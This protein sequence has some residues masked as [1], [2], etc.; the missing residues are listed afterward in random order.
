M[1]LTSVLS[2]TNDQLRQFELLGISIM[3]SQYATG[4]SL[5]D[6]AN[7]MINIEGASLMTAKQGTVEM[8]DE[9]VNNTS[10][11]VASE[12]VSLYQTNSAAIMTTIFCGW[13]NVGKP[14]TTLSAGS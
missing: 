14:V 9:P 3:P 12:L 8:T 5:I 13:V 11:P 2:V 4:L 7:M 10:E 1:P 6:P